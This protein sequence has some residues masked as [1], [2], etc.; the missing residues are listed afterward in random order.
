MIAHLKTP[1]S[2]S[3]IE[4]VKEMYARFAAGNTE[5]I[6]GIFAENVRWNMMKGFPG[7]GQYVGVDA[8]FERVFAYLSADWTGWKAISTHFID[9]GDGVFVVG[10]YEGT[11]KETGKPVRAE[12]A[13]EYKVAN[14]QIT[15]YNQYTDTFLVAQAMDLVSTKNA[16]TETI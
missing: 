11:Y 1:E 12:F 2:M 7:G 8:I 14:G 4:T 3:N 15:E 10:Y 16:Q 5:A 13:S 9:S 6:R